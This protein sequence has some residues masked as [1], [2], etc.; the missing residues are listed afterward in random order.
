M[1]MATRAILERL[2]TEARTERDRLS[3]KEDMGSLVYLPCAL[4]LVAEVVAIGFGV[5]ADAIQA[6]D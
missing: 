4:Y 1:K 2:A 3:D 6:E 5:V